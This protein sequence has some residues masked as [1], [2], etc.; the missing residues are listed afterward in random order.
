MEAGG[1][2][3]DDKPHVDS[4]RRDAAIDRLPSNATE[5]SARPQGTEERGDSDKDAPEPSDRMPPAGPHADPEL[6]N[7]DATPGTGTLQPPGGHDD[8]DSTSG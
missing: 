7:P 2:A 4:Q 6:I 3:D 1:P 8:V 5:P